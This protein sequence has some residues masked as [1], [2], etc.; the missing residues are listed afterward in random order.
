MSS[1]RTYE[2]LNDIYKRFVQQDYINF[3]NAEELSIYLE[4]YIKGI[5]ED[6][7]KIELMKLDNNPI[8]DYFNSNKE[9]YTNMK[10][11]LNNKNFIEIKRLLS[12]SLI[13]DS[14]HLYTIDNGQLPRKDYYTLEIKF[15]NDKIAE[16][17][18]EN[19]VEIVKKMC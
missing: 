7:V 1:T 18:K 2:D 4:R 19:K 16:L 5:N 9:K 3:K 12:F 15:I 13:F 11:A 10:D 8:Q 14:E 6:L 17:N